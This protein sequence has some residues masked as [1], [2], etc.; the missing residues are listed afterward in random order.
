[1]KKLLPI[2]CLFSFFV[3]KAQ[4]DPEFTHYMYN[5]SV[6]NP[7]YATA[8]PSTIDLGGFYR[9][10]WVGAVGSPQTFSFFSHIPLSAKVET[11][12][13]FINDRIGEGAIKE[14]NLYAD[15]AYLLNLSEGHRLSLGVKAGLTFFDSNFDDF[16]LES[17]GPKTDPAF[18]QNLHETFPVFG[19]GAYYFTDQ[20]YI[21][22][23]TPNLLR[24]KH[25]DNGAIEG[26]G[27]E[28]IH[29]YLT[30][31][32]VFE[33]NS[34]FKLKPSFLIRTVKGVSPIVDVSAN[35]LYL[36]RFELGV[37]YRLDDSFSG[38]MKFG[39]TP[40][41]DIG[42]A[43]DHTVSNLGTFESGTHEIFLLYRL[44]FIKGHNKSPR[45]F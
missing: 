44:T 13:S 3:L 8:A 40:T 10:Q 20:Y 21:G 31:G 26:V 38:L 16:R 22:F 25:L 34:K 14:N 17:G 19:A 23:S 6:I 7:G 12:I 4:Q 39:I 5:M 11:G 1:M 35:V 36:D 27:R 37:S 33:I 42:Y 15:F 43:Y 24:S 32:Y 30:G 29:L 2:F 41:F 28:D 18:A 45:F 9:N